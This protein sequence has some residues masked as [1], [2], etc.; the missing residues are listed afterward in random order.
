VEVPD[1]PAREWLAGLAGASELARRCCSGTWGQYHLRQ[2]L[3]KHLPEPDG[4]AATGRL[5][6]MQ[7]ALARYA[8][9]LVQQVLDQD[10]QGP[11]P[12]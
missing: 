2:L 1:L 11:P 8:P 12:A 4:P 6:S 5:M 10:H 9:E 3:A 7:E